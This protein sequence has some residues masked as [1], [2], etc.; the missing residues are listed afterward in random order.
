MAQVHL[1]LQFQLLRGFTHSVIS[2]AEK[3]VKYDMVNLPTATEILDT[4]AFV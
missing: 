3:S 2:E 4:V 1:L